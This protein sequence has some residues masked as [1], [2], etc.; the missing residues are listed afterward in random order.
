MSSPRL[1]RLE[2]DYQRI[3]TAFAGHPYIRVDPLRPLPPERYTVVYSVPGLLLGPDGRLQTHNQHIVQ[4]FLPSAY[5]REKPY[6]TT[7]RE[8]FHPNFGNHICIADF[9]S[10]GQ[11]LVDVI[12]QIGDMLQYKLY[13]TRSPLNAVAA[14]WAVENMAS[15]PIATLELMPKEPEIRIGVSAPSLGPTDRSAHA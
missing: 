5:P 9:W 7:Q 13:N 3:T 6:C 11:S 14:K 12:V 2:A 4:L 1:R 8:V 15:L 10:P